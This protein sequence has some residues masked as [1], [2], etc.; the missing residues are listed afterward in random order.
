MTGFEYS[1]LPNLGDH[2]LNAR[3]MG[4]RVVN[5]FKKG[6][7]FLESEIMD[8][9][10]SFFTDHMGDEVASFE[11]IQTWDIGVGYA[12]DL[13]EHSKLTA[14]VKPTLSSNFSN[15]IQGADLVWYYGLSLQHQ[16]SVR[17]SH[18][19]LS[20]GLWHSPALGEPRFLPLMS[21]HHHISDRCSYT[22]GFPGSEMTLALTNQQ[23]LSLE[24]RFNGWYSNNSARISLDGI[25][26]LEN[27]KLIFSGLDAGLVHRAQIQRNLTAVS[28]IGYSTLNKLRIET[29]SGEVLFDFKP[30]TSIYF[31]MG[32]QLNL[33]S[34][35]YEN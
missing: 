29:D 33:N 19:G 24:S 13:S 22:L 11:N 27:T 9:D 30:G 34:S 23:S 32:F 14:F 12:Y 18:F 21:F 16:W 10:W 5:A 35:K 28:R 6:S 15:G 2:Q 4:I 25:R 3:K 26:T 31:S 7:L 20:A 17:N 1:F 8:H